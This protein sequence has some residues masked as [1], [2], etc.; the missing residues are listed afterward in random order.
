MENLNGYK[1]RLEDDIKE[2]NKDFEDLEN[3]FEV[4]FKFQFFFLIYLMINM[5]WKQI[6]FKMIYLF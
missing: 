1:Q 4:F 6:F 3:G 5:G 2:K